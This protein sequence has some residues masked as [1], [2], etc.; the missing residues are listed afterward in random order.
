M[1]QEPKELTDKQAVEAAVAGNRQ[2]FDVLIKRYFG[3][4]YVLAFARLGDRT[5]SEDL[6]QEVFLR[7]YLNLKK[8]RTPEHFSA[9]LS[10]MA[11]NLAIDWVRS[12]QSGSRL[13]QELA[14]ESLTGKFCE[15]HVASPREKLEARER[16]QRVRDAI[17]KLPPTQREMVLLHYVE[18][19]TKAEIAS[20]LGVHPSTVGRQLAEALN[21][22]RQALL[23]QEGP[24]L[25]R[26]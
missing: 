12:G 9:W 15:A 14:A 2:A 25:C 6:A 5:A 13:I 7:A 23:A 11:R 24:Q 10:Q 19:V 21:T 3:M 8:L 16:E 1:N 18:E 4:I 20:R 17:A 26:E 22:I